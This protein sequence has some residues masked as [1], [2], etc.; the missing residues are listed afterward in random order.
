MYDRS[1][2]RGVCL[3][4]EEALGLLEAIMM[5][6]AELDAKQRA[7]MLKLS[8]F[9]RQ[10]LREGAEVAHEGSTTAARCAA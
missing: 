4:E 5:C 9:C 1:N 7:A 2:E 6:P 10:F 8:D 3:T